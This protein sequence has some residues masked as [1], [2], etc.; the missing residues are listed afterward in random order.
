[1][2]WDQRYQR[3]H[4]AGIYLQEYCP[5]QKQLIGD[6]INILKGTELGYTKAPHLYKRD[7][8]YYLLT[9]EGGTGYTHAMT[10]ARSRHLTGPYEVDPQGYLLTA[11]DH[12]E[13]P[14]QRCGHGDLADTPKG[15]NYLVHLSGRPLEGKGR[16]PHGRETSLQKTR[17]SEDGRLR[18]M[19]ACLN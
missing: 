9:A 16:C 14:L 3:N 11:K 15:E 12:P 18:L 4:F 8:W 13:L 6:I 10:L 1:M 17:W 5:R 19:M 2:V 7:G